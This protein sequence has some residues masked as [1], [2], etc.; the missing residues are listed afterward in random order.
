MFRDTQRSLTPALFGEFGGAILPLETRPMKLNHIGLA[1]VCL[2]FCHPARG[3]TL[4]YSLTY[5]E[6]RASFQARFANVAPFPGGRTQQQNLQMLRGTR[7]TEIYSL[8]LADGACTLLFTDE[9]KNLEIKVP[10]GVSEA[11]EV[12]TAGT[13]REYRQTPA[14]GVYSEEGVYEL[15]LDR[16]NQYRKIATLQAN[17]PP[18]ILNVQSTKALVSAYVNE[19]FMVDIYSL[20]EWK[21][22]HSWDLMHLVKDSCGGCTPVSYGWLADGKRVFVYLTV[23]GDEDDTSEK[24]GTYLFSEEGNSFGAIPAEA[25][26]LQVAGYV[27]PN[28][29]ERHL[30]GQLPDGRYL[31]LDYAAKQGTPGK[32]EP[33]LVVS[34]PEAKAGTAFPMHFSI[35][36]AFVSPSGKHIAY[37]EDRHTPDYRTEV[38]LWVKDLESGAERELLSVPPPNPPSSPEPN[39][40]LRVLGW[41]GK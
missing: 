21:L 41:L 16:S 31:F 4:V 1:A 36:V 6:T 19:K 23:V 38:H 2:L 28:Y 12:Y 37:L 7:K 39:V 32:T 22:L 13:W 10:G 25:G 20:P 34:S 18:A 24:P 11:G 9:G 27:H 17:Q 15:A 8:S 29:I 40:T 33:F 30:L 14:P 35:G 3:Q 5:V 26:A